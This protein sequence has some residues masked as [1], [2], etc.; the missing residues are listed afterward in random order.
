MRG[1]PL[2]LGG[3]DSVERLGQRRLPAR[4]RQRQAARSR[5]AARRRCTT[6]RRSCSA[7]GCS[8]SAA[9]PKPAP[10]RSRR[11]RR[12]AAPSTAGDRRAAGRTSADRALRPQRGDDRRSRLRARRLRR[13]RTDRLGAGDDRRQRPSPRS[14]RC[15][16]PARYLAVAALGGHD[17]R[18]RRRDRERR[19]A[20]TRSRQSTPRA[21]T[22]RV[23]GHLPQAALPRRRGRRSAAAST[24]SAGNRR[25]RRATRSGAST[26]QR[27]G[28]RGGQAAASGLRRRR[29]RGRLHRLPDRRHGRRG[30]AAAVRCVTVGLRRERVAPQPAPKPKPQNPATRR[31][32]A[33]PFSGRLLIADRG[34]DRLLVVNADKKVL[35]HF[36]SR[37]HPA[38]PGG[39]YF[40][41]DAFFIHGGTG[42]ISN[43]EQNERIVQLSFPS[44]KLLWSYGHPGVDRLRTGLPARARRRLPAE[45]RDGHGRR[46]AELPRAADLPAKEGP[47]GSSATRPPANHEP[48][49]AARLPQRRHAAAQRQHPRLRGQRLLHRRDHPAGQARLDRAAADRIPLRPPAARPRPL[50]GRRLHPTP[51]GSTSSTAPA[52]SSG[53][54]TRPPGQRML[55]HPSLAER[56]PNGLIAVNDDYRDRVVIIDPQTSRIVW[57]YGI[58]GEPGHRPRPAPHPRRLRPAGPERHH[59]DPPVHGLSLGAQAARQRRSFHLFLGVR[60]RHDWYPIDTRPPAPQTV[61]RIEKAPFP[62][63]FPIAGA[64]FVSRHHPRIRQKFA[65]DRT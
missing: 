53:P 7:T 55:N 39:F 16:A 54:T 62:G 27:Q 46:R 2:I 5:L 37:A 42:I 23:V 14:R 45:G 11:C 63:P 6:P 44:G 36:P 48:P 31:R 38:P 26:R 4:R 9:A 40:P 50:P 41:D 30:T 1:G 52:R 19:L 10:T 49:T 58:T 61:W 8:S 65:L 51:A 33:R 3:L 24:C 56:L 29:R 35:W 64:R 57:Q 20:A 59:A 43:E 13:Q 32:A 47:R 22:A 15:P 34:N 12:R 28:R 21:G 18:L 25:R 60:S 17:L